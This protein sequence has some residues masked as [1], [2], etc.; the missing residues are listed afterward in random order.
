MVIYVCVSAFERVRASNASVFGRKRAH[1]DAGINARRRAQRRP[2][3]YSKISQNLYHEENTP[4]KCPHCEHHLGSDSLAMHDDH[5]DCC[6]RYVDLEALSMV[7]DNLDF[8][9]TC[10]RGVP[11]S[12][13]HIKPMN[14]HHAV[15]GISNCESGDNFENEFSN[16]EFRQEHSNTPLHNEYIISEVR[17]RPHSTPGFHD[18]S[19]LN[20]SKG[21]LVKQ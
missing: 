17:R 11:P 9:Q 6:P 16:F 1:S 15:F 14:G 5:R 21:K 2:V 18:P 10:S 13:R 4:Y 12:E 7:S 19:N 20:S 3:D 8:R